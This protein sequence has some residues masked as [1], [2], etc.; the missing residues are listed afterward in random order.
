MV[1]GVVQQII[2]SSW[3]EVLA[4]PKRAHHVTFELHSVAG[5]NYNHCVASLSTTSPSPFP[6]SSVSKEQRSAPVP[7]APSPTQ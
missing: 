7:H 5:S 6:A 2:L 4:S 1:V 3:V